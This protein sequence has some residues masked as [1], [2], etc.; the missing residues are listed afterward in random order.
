M[1][2]KA[3]F[4]LIVIILAAVIFTGIYALREIY[5]S[6]PTRESVIFV[7]TKGEGVRQISQNLKDD[8]LIGNKLVFEVYIYLKKIGHKFQAGEY[9]LT[10]GWSI[11]KLVEL[12][13]SG[14][15]LSK[16]QEIKIIEGWNDREIAES[17]ENQGVVTADDFLE[18]IYD[19]RIWR[20]KYDF[21]E[22]KPKKASLEGYLFPDTYRIYKDASLDDI[23]TKMLDNFDSKLTPE[24]REDIKE[25]GRTIFEI[26]TMASIIELEVPT[27][28]DRKMIADIFWKRV[29]NGVALQSDATINY[30]TGKGDP[31][32]SLEDLKVD[33]LYNTYLYPDLPPGPIGNPGVSAIEAAIYPTPNEYWF[34]LS[35]PNGETVF[36]KDHDEHVR[37]KQK[38][39]K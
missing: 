10:H 30:I 26:I 20:G 37:N 9:E 14:R 21:L 34:Y 1:S 19:D 22:D 32:P 13:T 6:N 25:Q 36:G 16:E 38:W 31:T 2:K 18:A 3:F 11:K 35:K 8:G 17:L 33:S 12:L 23:I 4:G 39:L 28:G 5:N 24:M 15:A 29:D 7:I 27:D